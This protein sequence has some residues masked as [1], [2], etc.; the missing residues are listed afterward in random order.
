MN[1]SKKYFTLIL[2]IVLFIIVCA[3]V[4]CQQ[5]EWTKEIEA[6]INIDIP[7]DEITHLEIDYMGY[8]YTIKNT[9]MISEIIQLINDEPVTYTKKQ[10]KHFWQISAYAYS[11]KHKICIYSGYKCL[12]SLHVGSESIR[13]DKLYNLNDTGE[14]RDKIEDMISYC[15]VSMVQ[16]GYNANKFETY[17]IEITQNDAIDEYN[18]MERAL[19]IRESEFKTSDTY[20]FIRTYSN[21]EVYVY[22]VGDE[23]YIEY[24]KGYYKGFFRWKNKL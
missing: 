17:G 16:T 5:R 4:Y 2:V 1:K 12:T 3:E 10:K 19:P 8:R 18:S 20:Y 9:E 23:K 13:Y 11:P 21:E 7:I 6:Q 24:R 15:Q 22:Y 14:L